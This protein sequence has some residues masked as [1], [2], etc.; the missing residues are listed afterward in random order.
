MYIV[1]SHLRRCCFG[2][3][4]NSE[5]DDGRS[6]IDG[7]KEWCAVPHRHRL[8]VFLCKRR[9]PDR[10]SK[11]PCIQSKYR[12][13]RMV[14]SCGPGALDQIAVRRGR[15]SEMLSSLSGRAAI[16][17]IF[18]ARNPTAKFLQATELLQEY[19][20]RRSRRLRRPR[21]I[22]LDRKV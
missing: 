2:T 8:V 10:Q 13:L 7:I 21:N 15:R 12:E 11:R 16:A 18:F 14:A 22:R 6:A 4:S 1:C 3:Y 19:G 9:Q 17:H 5:L 20:C